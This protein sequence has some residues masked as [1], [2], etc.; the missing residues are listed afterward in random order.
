MVDE[1][2][3][4]HVALGLQRLVV[5]GAY[6]QAI[7][8][9]GGAGRGRLRRGTPAD[10]GVHQA[11]AAVG[12]DAQLV[13]VAESRDR[14]PGLVGGLDDHRAL[15]G[16]QLDA[17]DED[18]DVVRRQ[19]RVHRLRAHATASRATTTPAASSSTRKRPLRIA[20]SNS[21]RKWRMKPCTGQAAASPNAQMVWP[22][23]WPAAL[24]SISRSSVVARMS[25][26]R[27]SM[28][29]IQPVPSRHGVHWPQLSLK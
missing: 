10:F 20:Y 3:F 11:H 13:V 27:T 21:W 9:R 2:E 1:Q 6:L 23:I 25:A 28:R 5:A 19:V 8:H 18:G 17:V 14:D 15:G 26:I 7:H 22:S 16:G 12:G 4:H 24:R 29:Y